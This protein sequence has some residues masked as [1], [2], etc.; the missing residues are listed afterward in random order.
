MTDRDWDRIGELFHAALALAP[1][2]RAEFL[3]GACGDDAGLRCEVAEM[4]AAHE[5]AGRLVVEDRFLADDPEDDPLPGR[6]FGAYRLLSLLG[7]GGMGDVYLAERSD[8]QYERLVAFKLIRAGHGGRATHERFLRER[9]ILA[10]LEHPNIAML[11]DGGVI[12]D[13]RPYLVMQYV[14]GE[15]ITEWCRRREL[16][17]RGRLELFRVVCDTVQAAH[18]NL[19]VHRDLKP[20]N[21]LVTAD[22][23]VK[24]LDFGI[25]K[26]LDDPEPGLTVAL[27]RLLTPEHAAP[28]QVSG[29]AV[30]TATDVYALGV[31]LYELLTDTRPFAIDRSSAGAIERAICETVPPPPSTRASGLRRTLR[32]ELDNIVLKALR[33]EP[34]RRYQ[35]A[36]DL[37]EDVA[38]HLAGRP[39]LAQGDTF[40]Y[41]ARKLVTRHRWVAAA[42]LAVVVTVTW[43][44]GAITWQSRQTAVER[45]RALAEQT[46][47][48]AVI[49]V[50][51]GL[52]T[53]VN[54]LS[55][56][57][58][59]A[60]SRDDFIAMLAQ[61]V[62]DLD[63]Q[64]DVQARLRELLADVYLAHNRFDEALA[65][66][67][68][69]LAYQE[70]AG[71]DPLTLARVLHTQAVATG[72][73]RGKAVSQPLL[74]ASVARHRALLGDD[75]PDLGI[76]LQE[77][78]SAL[79][80]TAPAEAESLIE[81]AFVIAQAHAGGDSLNMAST[82]N[83]LGAVALNGGDAA[84]ARRRFARTLE[85]LRPAL[86]ETHPHVLTVTHNLAVTMLAPGEWAEA[87]R[88][89]RRNLE[90]MGRVLG[91]RTVG[92]ARAWDS[93]GIVLAFQGRLDEALDA[94]A[95]AE[96]VI[97]DVKGDVSSEL[98]VTV[99]N[100]AVVLGVRG[101]PRDALARFEEALA[102]EQQLADSDD[103]RTPYTRGLSALPRWEL[104]DREI[105]HADLQAGLVATAA[106][107]IGSRARL[108]SD[109][110][111][112]QAT[113]L[114]AEERADAAMAPARRA[115][116]LRL[117][118]QADI[119]PQ[120]ALNRC[121]V[122]AALAGAGRRDEARPILAAHADEA[123]GWG[124]AHPLSERLIA[125]A[126]A[127][128]GLR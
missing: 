11:L 1:D 77:L 110:L 23:Q 27:D 15:P 67:A 68:R 30:T 73:A 59:G 3:A 113:L 127:D 82:L 79:L 65:A 96:E 69:V 39:V 55:L 7:R 112:I 122:A 6:T 12:D 33:K 119:R 35:S 63:D 102:L 13:G 101:R 103:L 61:A 85:L 22:G 87:E 4:L 20:A 60:V 2:A 56:P 66:L 26:L 54:P 45:D 76:A 31:L 90:I 64:P 57:R 28:E 50:L 123:F 5:D 108:A 105:A 95:Q 25:A 18:N 43:S 29:R 62:D 91:E 106:D 107:T 74:R 72:Y 41:R 9:R 89:H 46:R 94:F 111:T 21:I 53:D 34:H 14:A 115:L 98:A 36:R 24:L 99:R 92:V 38:N 37:G 70:Q 58:D 10:Q 109:L 126:R 83:R 17:L 97:R 125:R 117:R 114:L 16:S 71:A 44:L 47:A 84:S 8:E 120:V 93:L 86:G 48:D 49:D 104:G 128:C 40:A 88:L 75:H 80:E 124:L 32:G 19:I 52:L 78:A 100:S 51:S 116:A 121:L 81:R 42:V 118:A